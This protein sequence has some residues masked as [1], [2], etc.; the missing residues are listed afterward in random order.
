[1][2]YY[3]Y[4]NLDNTL[5]GAT[6]AYTDPL[7]PV[8]L[9]TIRADIGDVLG[10][11][12]T[13]HVFTYLGTDVREIDKHCGAWEK[14]NYVTVGELRAKLHGKADTLPVLVPSLY[15]EIDFQSARTIT[16][17]SVKWHMDDCD[18]V[19]GGEDDEDRLCLV[20]E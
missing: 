13:P 10:Y 9:A 1:M 18:I 4:R 8:D 12:L 16:V 7:S 20:I 2:H 19:D 3:Q 6:L 17:Q 15:S 11:Y 14:F 5:H